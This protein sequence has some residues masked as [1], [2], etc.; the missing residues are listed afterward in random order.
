MLKWVIILTLI[1]SAISVMSSVIPHIK[2]GNKITIQANITNVGHNAL[3]GVNT[4]TSIKAYDASTVAQQSTLSAGS[5]ATYNFGTAVAS[6]IGRIFICGTLGVDVYSSIDN[7]FIGSITTPGAQGY[8]A[9]ADNVKRI[10]V[11]GSGSGTLACYDATTLAFIAN[12]TSLETP[13]GGLTYNSDNGLIYFASNSGANGTRLNELNPTTLAVSNTSLWY[14]TTEIPGNVAYIPE[15]GKIYT[16]TSRAA[17]N[18]ATAW[19]LIPN[20]LTVQ[21]SAVFPLVGVGAAG[22]INGYSIEYINNNVF[23]AMTVNMTGAL[24]QVH[25]LNPISNT[26]VGGF[27]TPTNTAAALKHITAT[28]SVWYTGESSNLYTFS[29]SN[30]F[31]YSSVVLV[32]ASNGFT[33]NALTTG[34]GN[35]IINNTAYAATTSVNLFDVNSSLSSGVS[36]TMVSGMTYDQFL[37][38]LIGQPLVID[39]IDLSANNN[40]Q[41]T[42]T[43]SLITNEQNGKSKKDISFP[44]VDRFQNQSA[45]LGINVGEFMLNALDYISYNIYA[46]QT[47]QMTLNARFL[48]DKMCFPLAEEIGNEKLAP[49]PLTPTGILRPTIFNLLVRI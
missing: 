48:E 30:P 28:G 12:V 27:Y 3:V 7:S 45:A 11:K 44:L 31:I 47:V 42:Q 6:N 41:L 8:I 23:F 49:E 39:S 43:L 14:S 25:I 5:L 24:G 35:F 16:T 34:T 33:T 36:V 37:Q 18:T 15:L 20:S 40:T 26:F 10:F 19:V 13:S 21:A 9:Y 38:S 22:S 17:Q 1:L 46:G 32:S 4:A 2:K 29:P